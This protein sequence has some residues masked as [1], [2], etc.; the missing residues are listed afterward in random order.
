MGINALDACVSAYEALA[1]LR[2]QI[3]PRSRIH[4]IIS[5][6][7]TRIN[8]ISAHAAIEFG[9]RAQ[10]TG[11]LD[12]LHARVKTAIEAG[13][14]GVHGCRVEIEP[15]GRRHE[16]VL[17][18]DTMAQ[19]YRR[20]HAAQGAQFISASVLGDVVV[21]TD[22]GNVSHH[23]PSIHPSF[24]IATAAY[25]HTVEFERASGAAAAQAPTKRA[26]KSMALTVVE[27]LQG[28]ADLMKKIRAE[29]DHSIAA[30]L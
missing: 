22:M 24:A 7:G 10:T 27:M 26:A 9:L 8:V 29:F 13:A 30:G 20:V 19:I 6:G 4:A 21:S 5:D 16:S 1:R 12:Q 15:T 14:R 28:G 3:R 25:P 11:E 18:N 17:H 2:Q 23:V